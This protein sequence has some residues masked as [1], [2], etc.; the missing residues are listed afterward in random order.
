MQ[1]TTENK[2]TYYQLHR[3]AILAK[4]KQRYHANLE[5][6]RLKGRIK[7][8]Q[9]KLTKM[10]ADKANAQKAKVTALLL[11]AVAPTEKQLMDQDTWAK[12]CA[13]WQMAYDIADAIGDHLAIADL[14]EDKP[15]CSQECAD[16]D[17]AKQ[18][19]WCNPLGPITPADVEA[20]NDAAKGPCPLPCCNSSSI[21]EWD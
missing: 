15:W 5:E 18:C 14:N 11:E 3:E 21:F 20:W 9:R 2:P 7:N 12:R 13:K 16:A 19:D 1:A 10:Q 8:A 6:N 4:A 17:D